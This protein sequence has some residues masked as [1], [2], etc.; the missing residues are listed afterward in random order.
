MQTHPTKRSL[1]MRSKNCIL[2]CRN[3]SPSSMLNSN[4]VMQCDRELEAFIAQLTEQIIEITKVVA[5]FDAANGVYK[6]TLG[7]IDST[8]IKMAREKDIRREPPPPPL[9]ELAATG[10][11]PRRDCRSDCMVVWRDGACA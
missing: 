11:A 5:E 2:D 4:T 8:D 1:P 9:S 7:S 6:L 10:I 3:I